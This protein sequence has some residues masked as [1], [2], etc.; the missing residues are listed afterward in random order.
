M[1]A[2]LVDAAVM[3]RLA[4]DGVLATLCPDGVYW[5]IRP[6]GSPAP[7]AF[8]IV[9]LFDHRE[10]PALASDTLYEK[11]NYLVKAVIA[12]TS[13]TPARQAAA[14][15]HELLH[16]VLL[17]LT[18]AGYTAMDFRRLDRVSYPEIDLVNKATW[19][20]AGGQYELMSYPTSSP[21]E[22]GTGATF[23]GRV[24]DVT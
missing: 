6:G 4:N 5:G 12:G 10:E 15:I 3:E 19:H 20:H 16:G 8:V 11:T 9:A 2:G 13:K 7:G 21:F 24:F 22:T 14:R 18:A 1:D 23:D 17:D